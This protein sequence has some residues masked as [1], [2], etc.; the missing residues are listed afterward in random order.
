MRY[1]MLGMIVVILS[2]FVA[3]LFYDRIHNLLH[4]LQLR[5]RR[6]YNLVLRVFLFCVQNLVID[7]LISAG[8]KAPFE[9]M[10]AIVRHS[11]T[12]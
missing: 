7:E 8:Q 4:R 12:S 11:K 2:T 1:T 5:I 9:L 6:I 3:A 10:P